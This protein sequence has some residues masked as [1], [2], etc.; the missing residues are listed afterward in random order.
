MLSRA[1]PI[2]H[3]SVAR[4]ANASVVQSS[5]AMSTQV[6]NK[7]WMPFTDNK[8]FKENPKKIFHSAK[9]VH[10]YL[11]DGTPILD[12][13]SGLWCVNAGHGQEKIVKAIQNQAAKLDFAP[14]FN[15][16]HKLPFEF[17]EKILDLL[18]GQ[19]FSNVF[20]TMCGSTA[21]DSALKMALQYHRARGEGNKVRFI[22]RDRGYH[23]VGFGG[24][25]SVFV[26]IMTLSLL[27]HHIPPGISVGGIGANRKAFAGNSLPHVDHIAAT[28]SLKDM[29]YSK[30][31]PTWGAHL[32]EDLERVVALHDASNIAAVVRSI[33]R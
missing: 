4:A 8:S 3:K 7:F 14:S 21:V 24:T 17:S 9:G 13:M 26:L 23:G 12:G 5:A 32:A 25:I 19:G 10:Y 1:S 31:L 27:A 29:A 28:H 20:F 18:P 11:E 15:T 30:G 33:L 16:S 2:V 6:N 22:G